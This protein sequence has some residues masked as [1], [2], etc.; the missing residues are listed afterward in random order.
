M[1]VKDWPHFFFLLIC[2]KNLKTFPIRLLSY[3]FPSA[4]L[5]HYFVYFLIVDVLR[6]L[7]YCREMVQND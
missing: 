7:V 2:C 5:L 1:S 4:A 3:A 6:P